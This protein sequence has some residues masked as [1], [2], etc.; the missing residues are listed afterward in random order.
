MFKGCTKLKG[1]KGTTYDENFTD[2]SYARPDGGI[3][4]PGYFY[5]TDIYAVLSSDGGTLTFYYDD[6]KESRSGKVYENAL[7]DFSGRH[8]P[9]WYA[10]SGTVTTVVFDESMK[11]ARPKTLRYWFNGF[12]QLTNIEDLNNLDTRDVTDMWG[13]FFECESLT[14]LDLSSFDT[15]NVTDMGCMFFSC[16]NLTSIDLSCFDTGNVT[17]MYCMFAFCESITSLDVSNFDTGKVETMEDM[18]YRCSNLTTIYCN[19]DWSKSSVLT[20]SEGMFLYNYDL[21]G[22][23]GT[24]YDK[25]HVDAAYARPDEG[26][27]ALGYF[28]KPVNNGDVND[29]GSVDVADISTIIDIMAGKIVSRKGD[30]NIDGSV[31]VADISTVIDIMAGKIVIVTPQAPD[32]ARGIDL[33]LPSGTLWANINIGADNPQDYGLYFAWGDTEGYSAESGHVC[34]WETYKWMAEG[35]SSWEHITKYT[36][37][38]GETDADWYEMDYNLKYEFTGDGRTQLLL[39]DDAARANWGGEWRMPTIEHIREL[40]KYTTSEWTTLGGVIGRKFTSKQ[41]GNAI[42]LPAAGYMGSNGLDQQ[43][44]T[45]HYWSSSLGTSRSSIASELWFHST[46]A[47]PFSSS[48]YCGQSVRPIIKGKK[49]FAE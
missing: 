15:R 13:V 32:Y 8:Y 46:L 1:G 43:E 29:D 47:D 42:F 18:F 2:A 48:R 21:E 11:D 9:Q 3:Y 4:D 30:V 23:L 44:R 41:N 39:V 26:P 34:T 24:T 37:D 25:S 45:G 36:F 10:S 27:T 12:G 40:K 16:S 22:G 20:N 35:Q 14:A 49:P 5:V 38:D 33:G 31:D 28:T 6:E 7:A 19:N 17:S